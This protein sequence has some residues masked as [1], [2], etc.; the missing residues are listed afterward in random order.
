MDEKKKQSN[1]SNT[2]TFLGLSLQTAQT[3]FCG[4]NFFSGE[5]SLHNRHTS[6]YIDK[7][8]LNCYLPVPS[9]NC[10]S[11]FNLHRLPTYPSTTLQCITLPA[12]VLVP[13][14]VVVMRSSNS[15]LNLP[16]FSVR[17]DFIF[18]FGQNI[19]FLYFT[20]SQ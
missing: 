2:I 6:R 3:L 11:S 13:S 5:N 16:F 8:T 1:Q 7:N 19:R 20:Q 15:P 4:Y 17:F 9:Y 10:M 14:T 18:L 12:I